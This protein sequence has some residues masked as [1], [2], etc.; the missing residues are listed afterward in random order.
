MYGMGIDC[1]TNNIYI[2]T[3]NSTGTFLVSQNKKP[4]D[5]G[6]LNMFI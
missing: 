2:L 1:T 4:S 3:K 6:F 5:D